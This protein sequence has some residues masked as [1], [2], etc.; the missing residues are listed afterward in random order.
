GNLQAVLASVQKEKPDTTLFTDI[1]EAKQFVFDL[2]GSC[3]YDYGRDRLSFQKIDYPPWDLD[4]CHEYR[5][6]FP[7]V[8]YLCTTFGLLAEVDCVLFMQ[9]TKQMWGTSWLYRN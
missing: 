8:D 7:L 2:D 5:Y 1:E 3:G 9:N 4:F 6:S